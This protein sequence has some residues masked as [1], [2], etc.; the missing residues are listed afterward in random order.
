MGQ[1]PFRD[2]W[3]QVAGPQMLGWLLFASG[4]CQGVLLGLS[5]NRSTI[6]AQVR[7]H[8]LACKHLSS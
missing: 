1:E 6:S 8:F 4:V 2:R 7:K 5:S 3:A